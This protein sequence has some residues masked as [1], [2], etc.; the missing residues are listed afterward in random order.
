ME[1]EVNNYLGTLALGTFITISCF[2]IK[3]VFKPLVERKDLPDVIDK[4]KN[5]VNLND[6][7]T[8]RL[9]NYK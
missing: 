7:K 3:D 1:I 6:F 9:K 8:K 4:S 5:L 2:L